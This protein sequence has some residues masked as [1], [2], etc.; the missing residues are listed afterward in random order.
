MKYS[1]T[2]HPESASMDGHHELVLNVD[3]GH[4][5][6]EG[7]RKGILLERSVRRLEF[8]FVR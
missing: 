7:G 8:A 5:F 2:V 6:R 4:S 1:R 3:P